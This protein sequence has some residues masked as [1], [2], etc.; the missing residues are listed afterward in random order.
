MALL[1]VGDLA[2]RTGLTVR[3]IH[4]YEALGLLAPAQRT[5]TRHRL[6]DEASIVRLRK[7]AALKELGMSLEEI[8]QWLTDPPAVLAAVRAQRM[9]VA[10]ALQQLQAV[11][12]RLEAVE[13]HMSAQRAPS[14]DDVLDA[15]EAIRMFEKY[16]T[17]EQL[18]YLAKRR[19]TLGEA[20]I[21]E[22]EQEWPQLIA[23]VRDA[24]QRGLDP[25]SDEVRALTTRWK[26]LIEEFTGG[27]AGIEQS[28]RNLYQNEPS[29]GS[30]NNL[31]GDL[32]RYV[33]RSWQGGH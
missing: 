9:R 8:R 18:D 31:D 19:E 33:G 14:V 11:A 15:L 22:V 3:A 1:K 20:H 25:Q 4:H 6:Y 24:M 30:Q 21:K 7:I 2:Q 16:Y 17:P 28:L 5:Q 32:M 13:T 12:A 29:I 10:G 27:D 23:K 26:Q